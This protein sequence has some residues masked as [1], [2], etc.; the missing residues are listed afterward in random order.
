M[1]DKGQTLL[2]DQSGEKGLPRLL[3]LW[4]PI[5]IIILQVILELTVPAQYLGPLHSEGGPHEA[6]EFVF[7][8]LAC[9]LS[10]ICVWINRR[11]LLLLVWFSLAVLG[12]F[13]IAGEEISWGQH[14]FD[15]TTP[16]FW[17]GV[18]DQNETNLHNTSS[19]FD[20]K[21]RLLLFIGIVF[22]GL[23]APWMRAQKPGM[24][25]RLVPERYS[26][27]FPS[28]RLVP[29]VLGVLLPYLAQSIGR[30]VFH[31]HLFERESEVQELYMYYFLLLYTLE[32]I[33]LK[34]K[35]NTL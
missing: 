23:V 18:N 16:E 28:A 33:L 7:A 27:L 1:F 31:I 20:Q 25:A 8:A 5:L 4:V 3:W 10:L 24:Y 17:S 14:V 9:L 11:N 19:W 32:F 29:T 2:M 22:A 35:R 26:I 13:Y 15:W 34:N 6:V 12:C 30:H 21:P